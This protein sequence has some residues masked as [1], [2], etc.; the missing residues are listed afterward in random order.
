MTK[1]KSLNKINT[2]KINQAIALLYH[3]DPESKN[4]LFWENIN[5]PYREI[6][7]DCYYIIEDGQ[8]SQLNQITNSIKSNRL[9]YIKL[10]IQIH[11]VKFYR[12]YETQFNSFKEYCQL[13][14]SYPVWRANQV[15][16]A[17]A[18]AIKLI[19]AG[20]N[21]VPQNEAQA[22]ILT[23]LNDW[24]LIDKWQEVLDSYPAHKITT[25]RIEKIIYGELKI[26]KGN[27]KLP[28]KLLREIENKAL[29][30]GLSVSDLITKVFQGDILINADGN[31]EKN[32]PE[33]NQLISNPSPE[34]IKRWEKDLEKLAFQERNKIDEFADELAEELKNTVI[35]LKLAIKECFV[36]SFLQPFFKFDNYTP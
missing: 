18:V 5:E 11:Q 25:S 35:D 26:K 8:Y 2:N 13:A 1:T 21:I 30:N 23:K 19:K 33:N 31:L 10:G 12:L 22:R 27:L 28:I 6:L 14:I 15:I 24:E 7:E 17:S 9:S 36:K 4:E 34:M 29:E 20:F 32:P 16:Q 3:S